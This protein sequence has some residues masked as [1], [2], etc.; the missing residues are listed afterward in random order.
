[1]ITKDEIS[2][3]IEVLLPVYKTPIN[4]DTIPKIVD[5]AIALAKEV[6]LRFGQYHAN[7]VQNISN[8]KI[9]SLDPIGTHPPQIPPKAQTNSSSLSIL[10]KDEVIT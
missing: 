10:L 8:H 1:M 4:E 5:H 2:R 7:S 9:E 6:D 3:Y